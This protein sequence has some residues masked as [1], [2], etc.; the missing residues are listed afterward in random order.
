MHQAEAWDLVRKNVARFA[1]PPKPA[2]EEREPMSPGEIRAFLA[3]VR[4]DRDEALYLLATTTGMRRG[5]LFG[6]K[7]EDLDLDAGRYRVRR[8]LDTQYGPAAEND[9]KRRASRRPGILL[10]QVVASLR[11]HAD[12]QRA[13]RLKAGPRWSENG[14]VFPTNRGTPQRADNVLKR[15]L[16]PLCERH[17]LRRLT[18]TDLR[19]SV[20]TFLALLDVHPKTAQR[21]L[22]HGSVTTT[23]AVYTHAL[24]EMHADAAGRLGEF[25]FGPEKGRSP[26]IFLSG[27]P[28]G[29]D[30]GDPEQG[31]TPA[32]TGV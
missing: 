26:V 7:W 4:G 29:P 15:S 23:L 31:E 9:T 3:A 28:N 25:L 14:Y 20:A 27:A 13:D 10:P 18:F 32:N 30:Q 2:A 5:E 1:K 11:R 19:H 12:L 16:K 24:D 22:G 21:I 6:L 17:G 8:S